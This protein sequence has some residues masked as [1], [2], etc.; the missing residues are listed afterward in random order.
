MVR[1]NPEM[2][3]HPQGRVA[4]SEAF[5]VN[6]SGTSVGRSSDFA[7]NPIAVQ[8]DGKDLSP[9]ML[10]LLEPGTNQP[11]FLS[12]ALAINDSGD[13]VGRWLGG[14]G[15]GFFEAFL[16]RNGVIK[17]LKNVLGMKSSVARDI[18][19]A[20]AIACSGADTLSHAF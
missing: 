10:P 15:G 2:L 13:V 6:E 8:W 17:G 11:R 20:G 18:N 1:F 7:E 19:N 5:D 4:P 16:F 12:I 9:V 14:P 3:A